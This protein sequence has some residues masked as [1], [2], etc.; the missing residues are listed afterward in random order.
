[1]KSKSEGGALL[2]RRKGHNIGKQ[3]RQGRFYGDL[4]LQPDIEAFL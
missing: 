3:K 4:R 2:N 1:M